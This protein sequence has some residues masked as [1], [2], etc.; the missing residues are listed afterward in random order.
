MPVTE[1][2]PE[3]LETLPPP[4]VLKKLAL[5][6]GQ[7]HGSQKTWG[8]TWSTS[9]ELQTQ[10]NGLTASLA[11]DLGGSWGTWGAA[12]QYASY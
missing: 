8:A 2:V 10:F 4:P 11:A 9:L 6:D 5:V 1:A 3:L 12:P 7:E